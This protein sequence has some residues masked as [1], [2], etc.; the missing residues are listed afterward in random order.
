[1]GENR[2]NIEVSEERVG[3]EE[4]EHDYE[5]DQKN[6]EPPNRNRAGDGG[7][8]VAGL[9]VHAA[10]PE[11]AAEAPPEALAVR[12]SIVSALCGISA[13]TRPRLNTSARWQIRS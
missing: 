2:A 6:E 1:V 5:Y 13:A 8:K 11:F 4:R 9:F 12:R 10:A 7:A 3:L